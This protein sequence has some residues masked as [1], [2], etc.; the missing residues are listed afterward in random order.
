[1]EDA[2]FDSA[3]QWLSLAHYAKSWVDWSEITQSPDVYI[4]KEQY[5]FSVYKFN[6]TLHYLTYAVSPEVLEGAMKIVM[7]RMSRF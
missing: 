2:L 1:M 7:M 4:W 5:K 6:E 3:Q